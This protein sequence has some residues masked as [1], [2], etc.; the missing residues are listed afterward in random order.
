MNELE[1]NLRG[2]QILKEFIRIYK[3]RSIFESNRKGFS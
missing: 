2:H 3:Y 1:E